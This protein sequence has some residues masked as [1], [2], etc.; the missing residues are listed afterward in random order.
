ME[1][2]FD[3]GPFFIVRLARNKGHG[4]AFKSAEFF[5]VVLWRIF[6][7]NS[8]RLTQL[9]DRS[10]ETSGSGSQEKTLPRTVGQPLF[11]SQRGM[12]R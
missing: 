9:S 8:S 12:S 10:R 3:T 11:K 5:I 7:W 4:E 1:H 6:F 2:L